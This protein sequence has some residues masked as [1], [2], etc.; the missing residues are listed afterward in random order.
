MWYRTGADFVLLVHLGFV[1]F[2]MAG[3][4][5]LL[6]WRGLVWIHLP[7][8]AWGAL[9]EFSGWICPLTPLENHLRSLAGESSEEADFIGRYL[10][11]LLYPAGL[12][13]EIQLL[14]GMVVVLVN[15]GLY[16]WVL[17]R[18]SAEKA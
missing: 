6:K 14:L 2:V 17:F 5:L 18:P 1:L 7:A 3:G 9:V 4:L 16:W 12:T 8:V 15:L 11:A 13:R 10:P